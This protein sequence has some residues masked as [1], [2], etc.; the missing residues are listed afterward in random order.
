M[1]GRFLVEAQSNTLVFFIPY[2][3]DLS[4]EIVFFRNTYTRK[5]Y[6]FLI[7]TLYAGLFQQYHFWTGLIHDGICVHK[8]SLTDPNKRPVVTS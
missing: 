3:Q 2:L 6:P 1:G 8:F 7:S 5:L 4:Q